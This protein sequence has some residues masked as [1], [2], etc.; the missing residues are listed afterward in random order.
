MSVGDSEGSCLRVFVQ[1]TVDLFGSLYTILSTRVITWEIF[2]LIYVEAHRVHMSW[3][4]EDC[5]VPSYYRTLLRRKQC[6]IKWLRAS[7]H[8]FK[9]PKIIAQLSLLFTCRRVPKGISGHNLE[10]PVVGNTEV[11]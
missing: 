1:C 4:D 9:S 7:S 2:P 11:M 6:S 3:E 10:I 5:A 8:C